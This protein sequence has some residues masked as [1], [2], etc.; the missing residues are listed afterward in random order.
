[1]DDGHKTRAK[2]TDSAHR[3]IDVFGEKNL[4]FISLSDISLLLFLFLICALVLF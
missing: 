3:L 2:S 4:Y 1:M